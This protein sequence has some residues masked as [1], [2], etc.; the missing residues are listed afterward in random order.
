MSSRPPSENRRPGRDAA[1]QASLA[2]GALRHGDGQ[3]VVVVPRFLL[4]ELRAALD[5]E[6]GAGAGHV[7]YCIG[8]EW[9]LR[10]MTLVGQRMRDQPGGGQR[11][12]WQSDLDSWWEPFS[13]GGWGRCHFTTLPR[14]LVIADVTGSAVAAAGLAPDAGRPPSEPIC[15]LYAGLFAG[16]LSFFQRAERHAVEVQCAALGAP[17]CVFVAGASAEIDQVATWRQQNLPTDEIRRR[18]TALSHAAA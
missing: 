3:R 7:A 10:E 2:E 1:L 14:G 4:S 11:D 12:L 13:A 18:I 16:A 5:Q 17:L 9:A 8:F 6:F 15:N